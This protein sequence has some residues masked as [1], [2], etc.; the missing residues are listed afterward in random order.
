MNKCYYRIVWEN[1]P[2]GNTPINEQNLN[3]ID[4]AADEMDNRIISLDA[5][6]L[7][8]SEANLLVKYIE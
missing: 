1:Y 8:K 7:D 5:S 4:V 6:K 2:S 3:K